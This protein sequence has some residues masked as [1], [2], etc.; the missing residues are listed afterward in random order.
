M[1]SQSI[2]DYLKV[3]YKLSATDDSSTSKIAEALGISAASV[4]NMT[5]RL[6]K[7]NLA[8]H[9]AHKQVYLSKEGKKKALQIIRHHRLLETFL[10]EVMGYTW[11]EVH[12][13]AE[14]LEHHISPLFEKKMAGMLGN[15]EYD[16]HGDPIPGEDGSIPPICSS[17]LY[18]YEVPARIVIRRV[19]NTDDEL[20]RY[21]EERSLIPGTE[22]EII[23]KAPF[24]GPLTVSRDG[25]EEVIGYELACQ[26]FGERV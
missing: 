10:I 1:P 9:R 8:E 23:S 6:V 19:A 12:E 5:K 7:M 26:I 24:N 22:L 25:T 18:E 15:P 11:D 14:R 16:P 20:L 3:I 21:F 13:E 4:T 17:N 2:E